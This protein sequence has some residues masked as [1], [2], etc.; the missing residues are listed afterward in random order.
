MVRPGSINTARPRPN[1][2]CSRSN[3][4]RTKGFTLVEL[5]FVMV[6]LGIVASL[7]S[8][9]V[10][11]ALESY[12]DTQ[13]RSQVVQR[14]RVTLEQM[15]RQVRMAA[16]NSVRISPSGRCVEFL[17]VVGASQY[18]NAL[19]DTSNGRAP[20]STLAVQALSAGSAAP[21]HVVVAPFFPSEL[22][23]VSATAARVDLASLGTP[24]TATINLAQAHRFVRNSPNQRLYLTDDPV[25]F[26]ITDERLVRYWG[27]GLMTSAIN[28]LNPGGQA[29]LMAQEVSAPGAAFRLTPGSEQRNAALLMEL[30]FT[31]GNQA[32][33]LNHQV[34]IRNVP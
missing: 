7:G 33:T 1:A 29:A 21:R 25:R 19:P 20:G 24:P 8:S 30:R 13:Q 17:P 32:I 11:T 6:I 10:V 26:C 15:A 12:R 9:F 16:P 34:L 22:Y 18:L 5:I 3:P 27:Y 23:T 28:D 2:L 4:T 14:G 31:R